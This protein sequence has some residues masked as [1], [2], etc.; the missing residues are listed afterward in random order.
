MGVSREGVEGTKRAGW[1]AVSS[2]S[3]CSVGTGSGIGYRKA[4]PG[5][6]GL[7]LSRHEPVTRLP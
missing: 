1:K 5:G 3:R 4:L 6:R 7:A 2:K